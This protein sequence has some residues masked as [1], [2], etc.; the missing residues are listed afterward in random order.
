MSDDNGDD[1]ALE[2]AVGGGRRGIT[3]PAACKWPQQLMAD[4]SDEMKTN[5]RRCQLEKRS[6]VYF[7]YTCV[8]AAAGN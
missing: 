4:C 3:H 7:N 6:L 8:N 5:N 2:G 1:L